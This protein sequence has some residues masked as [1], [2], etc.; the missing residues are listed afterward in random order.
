M[1]TS[2]PTVQALEPLSAC[3]ELMANESWKP[4]LVYSEDEVVGVLNSRRLLGFLAEGV[5]TGVSADLTAS[6]MMDIDISEVDI[7]SSP[8]QVLQAMRASRYGVVI[9]KRFGQ[10]I[11]LLTE[12]DLAESVYPTL[13]AALVVA[14]MESTQASRGGALRVAH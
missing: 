8:P 9:V 1:G 3:L 4:A 11:G 6:D 2:S 7:F 5:G 14:S 10:A 12:R 13:D